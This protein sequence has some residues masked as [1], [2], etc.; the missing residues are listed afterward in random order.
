M[1]KL[2]DTLENDPLWYKD[3][4]LYEVHVRAFF[5]SN[6]DGVGDF[7]GLTQKLDY[8]QDLGVTAIWLLPFC[9]SPL[10]DDGYDISDYTNVHPSY[11]TRRDVQMFIREAHRRGLRVITELVVNHTSDQH[12][13]FQRARTS[14]PDSKWRNFYVWSKT[15]EEYKDARIIFKDTEHSNWTWD[16]VAKAYYWHRFFSHQPDLNYDNPD[17]Q[18]AVFE[19]L[20]F[21]L[22]MGVDGLRLDAVPYLFEREGT[23]CENLP[24]T[25]A[26]LKKL[27][28]YVDDKYRNRMLLAE[29]NQ[30]PEDA[31]AYFGNGDE[32]HMNYHFPLMPR[33]FMAIQME[34]R[35][36]IIDI[37]SQTPPIPETCQWALFLRNHDELTLEMVTDE[38]RDYMYRVFAR[39]RQARINLGIR[40]RL[41]PL[42]GNDYNKIKLINSLLFSMPG[43]PIIYY[44]EEIGM[45]DNY[46]LGDRNGVRTPMQW[47]G[48]RNAGFSR[49][50]PQKLYLPVIIDPEYHYEAINVEL[51]QNNPQSLLWWMKRMISLRKQFKVFGRGTLEFLHPSNR[52]V[53]V[54][55]R[56][57][58]DEIVLVAANL[59]RYPQCVELDLAQF[60]GMVPRSIF[61]HIRFPPIGELP[62]FLTLSGHTFYWFQLEAPVS[63]LGEERPVSLTELPAL[64]ITRD[65]SSLILRREKSRLEAI[66]PAYIKARRWFGGKARILQQV[67]IADALPVPQED[68]IVVLSWITVE[69]TEGEPET[70]FLPFRYLTIEEAQPLADTPALI[71]EVKYK[72]KGEEHL[73]LLCDAIWTPIFL[74]YLLD[75]MIRNR[76]VRG[77]HGTF[78]ASS[79]REFRRQLIMERPHLV[80]TI[81]RGEQSNTSVMYGRAFILKLFRKV[82]VGINPDLEIG[83]FLTAK[84][85]PHSVP[86]AGMLEY[87]KNG[88]TMT[89]GILQPYVDNEGDAWQYT[90]DE[91]TQ[92]YERA[93]AQPTALGASAIPRDPILTLVTH[94]VPSEAREFIGHYL[95]E[96]ELLGQRTGELHVTL[97]SDSEQPDFA[98]EPFTDFYRRSLYQSMV[99][100]ANQ[101]LPLLRQQIANLPDAAKLSAQQLL[102]READLRKRFQP[103]RMRKIKAKRIRIH[104][105][106]HLG[107]VLYTGKDFIIIDFEGE[108]ARPL[109]VRRLKESPLR[110]VAG[111]LRSFHY[112]AY[113]SI[114]RHLGGIRPEDFPVLEPWAKFWQTWVSVSFL[115]AY[116]A[117]V[118]PA[119]ILPEEPDDLRVLLDAYVIQK[120]IYE[121]G[122]E[123]NNRPDWAGIPLN[124]IVQILATPEPQFAASS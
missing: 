5:D 63:P 60:K 90:L 29:A 36:P 114:I 11:G 76:R 39:D 53:L 32:C 120:A 68:P 59:S 113:S 109:S 21:W 3:A 108:P 121:L 56:R 66:L 87:Q 54:Y 70:Y 124:G 99:G 97:A 111:M 51:Q 77:P 61:G 41:A 47:S 48:D 62:Y 35:F 67:T 100:L 104:G 8:L 84:G 106:Y 1:D 103:I 42:L 25:H 82:E 78:L 15:G 30:W 49:A 37:L 71:A 93:S 80:P 94:P 9:A 96:A 110:D 57:Y 13:W 14:P 115:K 22:S 27:R 58:E 46:Y 73:G 7:R 89:I 2:L 122:Y 55:L 117:V 26:F 4:I 91:L 44:G 10:R 95:E 102:E 12:P 116:L 101:N 52:K 81:L 85:F 92:Y 16:P 24:E 31:A 79:L 83:R 86:V 69:Y 64:T 72:Q 118:E 75:S 50:N 17:V 33:M 45:G 28:Q 105:D 6:N 19:V 34:D 119:Q 18:Q 40:R 88:E 65:W 98:P 23:N 38:E 112:A 74:Q 107:Q 123:L 20:D 43:T